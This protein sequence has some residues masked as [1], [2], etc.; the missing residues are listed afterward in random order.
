LETGVESTE[1]SQSAGATDTAEPNAQSPGDV[2]SS[3]SETGSESGVSSAWSLGVL[4]LLWVIWP[5]SMGSKT[6][7]L[8]GVAIVVSLPLIWW[9]ACEAIRTDELKVSRPIYVVI[10]VLLLWILTLPAYI[11]YRFVKRREA[12]Q[13]TTTD[14]TVSG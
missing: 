2:G 9:D 11:I 5:I 8:A 4:G 13:R 6:A 12:Q 7:A 3:D 10:A 1:D 14:G